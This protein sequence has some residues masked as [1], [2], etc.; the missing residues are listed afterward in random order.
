MRLLAGGLILLALELRECR[1]MPLLGGT[2]YAQDLGTAPGK[3][4]AEKY[5]ICLA[6]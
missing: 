2:Q 5:V 1:S 6:C 4:S 3:S